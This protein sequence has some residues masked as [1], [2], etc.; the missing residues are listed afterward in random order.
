M[1][2]WLYLL[3]FS[4]FKYAKTAR[5][6]WYGTEQQKQ[7]NNRAWWHTS[8]YTKVCSK[9]QLGL[10]QFIQREMTIYFMWLDNMVTDGFGKLE[11]NWCMFK[12]L[13]VPITHTVWAINSLFPGSGANMLNSTNPL[14]MLVPQDF[15]PFLQQAWMRG[16]RWMTARGHDTWTDEVSLFF[17]GRTLI[18]PLSTPMVYLWTWAA[19]DVTFTGF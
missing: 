8:I 7:V 13:M 14:T 12:Q 17:G 3:F 2:I 4:F 5:N 19:L 9:N 16:I 10:Y 11:N 15:C 6:D 18:W 1:A